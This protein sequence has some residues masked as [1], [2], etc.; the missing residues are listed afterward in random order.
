MA[1]HHAAKRKEIT[2][3]AVILSIILAIILAASNTF[4]ALKIGI[5]TSASIPAAILSMGIFRLFKRNNILENNLVQTAASAGEAVAGGIVYTIPALI[6]IHYWTHFSYWENLGIALSGGI[7]GVLFS[8]PIRKILVTNPQL[9]FPE[10][11]AIA[12]VL[13]A[14]TG[15]QTIGLKQLIIGGSIGGILEFAQSGLKVI[16]NSF[17]LWF[18]KGSTLFGLSG[19]LSA[20]LIG[21]GYL[22]GFDIGLSLLIGAFVAWGI[23]VPILSTLA[24]SPIQGTTA[25]TAALNTYGGKIHYIGIGAMLVA[26]IWTLLTLIK[27]FA[28]SLNIS[29]KGLF[30]RN[31]QN[32]FNKLP[33]TERDIPLIYTFGGILI[34]LVFTHFLFQRLFDV[35]SLQLASYLQ[36]L[37]ILGSIF[38]VLVIGFIFAVICGYFSGLVGV[39]ASP[40][41]AVIIAGMILAA[42]IVRALLSL[43][44]HM[45]TQSQLL[46]G[47]AIT[48][49]LGAV[50][51]G[52]SAIANDNIQDLKVGHI[53]GATPWKQQ[54]M[55]LLGV[56][57]AASVIPPIMQLLFNVY[58]IAN[59]F[60]HPGMNPS[61]TLAAP[62]AAMMAG[63]AQGVF[64]HD[65]PWNMLA[66]GGAIILAFIIIK[67]ILQK[68]LQIGHRLSILGLAIGIYLPLTSSTPL[69]LGAIIALFTKRFLQRKMQTADESEK[70]TLKHNQ[71][72]SWLAACGLVAGAALMDVIL[73][74]PM[75][76]AH[77]PDILSV[78]PSSLTWLAI[79]LGI[80]SVIGLAIWFYRITSK[81]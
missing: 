35:D 66:I 29:L 11:R 17:Q 25:I 59:V 81:I 15:E 74:I 65:L 9:P 31:F 3:P 6:I 34:M 10:G 32:N 55:L 61:Q 41:S 37:F 22:M 80:S 79:L 62:P 13:Q 72:K 39:T 45:L 58:G 1:Q 2:I 71:H 50:I 23:A 51:T 57:A 60:P 48:I 16:A 8:V 33:T 24:A 19:G 64:N 7:L 20:T 69:I 42:L 27:S 26:G 21:A 12:E 49:M 77:N 56:V 18:S 73:A 36:P 68:F 47:A 40:G 43:H 14:G 75:A 44:G 54:M 78:M 5:L 67:L 4:L 38:Y 30:R 70:I 53:I 52:S 28:V 63:L 46:H 76:L